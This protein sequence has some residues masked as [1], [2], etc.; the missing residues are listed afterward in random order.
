MVV[1]RAE[2]SCEFIALFPTICDPLDDMK[3]KKKV[4]RPVDADAVYART[5][6]DNFTSWKRFGRFF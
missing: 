3:L 4:D 1:M 6:P 2:W 5:S